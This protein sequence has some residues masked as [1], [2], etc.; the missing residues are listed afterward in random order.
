V[1]RWTV[2]GAAVVA[3]LWFVSLYALPG[4]GFTSLLTFGEREHW[5]YLEEL[6]EIDVYVIP[7][8]HGYDAQYYVQL[9]MRPDVRDPELVTAMDFLPYR[10]RR[11]LLSWT[12]WLFAGGDA[13]RAMHLYAVQNVIAW[14]ALGLVLLRWFPP[15]S[16]N[17]VVRWLGIMVS[18][19]LWLSVRNALVDGPSLL[20]IALGMATLETGR[21]WTSAA[22]LGVAGLARETNILAAVA[23]I[24]SRRS[25]RA[26]GTAALQAA[27]VLLPLALWV[28]YVTATVGAAQGSPAANFG[29]PFT[30]YLRE[31]AESLAQAREPS[32]FSDA[33]AGLLVL[34]SLTVQAL[35]LLLRPRVSDPWWRLGMVYLVLMAALGPAVWEG[36]PGAAA[37]V[38]LPM[39][40]AFNVLLPRGR[41]WWPVLLA[42]N[43]TV[44]ATV[45]TLPPAIGDVYRVSAP[46]TVAPEGLQVRFEDNW[47]AMEQ[48]RY[49]R[50]KWRWSAGTARATLVNPNPWPLRVR[51]EGELLGR[52]SRAV[53]IV[54]G[55]AVR[56]EGTVGPERQR[57][58]GAEVVLPPG[59]TTWLVDTDLPGTPAGERD[60]RLLAFALRDLRIQVTGGGPG[61]E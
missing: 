36:Y 21:R 48:S 58:E 12:A 9:A 50:D 26:W 1:A 41:W 31:W 3:F 11:I 33:Y 52:E 47:H 60:A 24:P 29:L 61:A 28:G 34:I 44:L 42:G 55:D 13:V 51:L 59:E 2:L 27:L 4:K 10:A 54:L 20:L 7:D 35:V 43:L 5:H 14:L 40:L 22:I 46:A 56:W 45:T 57:F 17:H 25:W 49:G 30:G 16:W 38:L 15:T 32:T 53:R 18:L 39:T 6:R 19:G 37:R 23:L 8:S